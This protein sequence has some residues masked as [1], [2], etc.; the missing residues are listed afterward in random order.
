MIMGI[1][2]RLGCDSENQNVFVLKLNSS[3]GLLQ[4]PYFISVNMKIVEKLFA[5]SIST[6]EGIGVAV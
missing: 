3:E 6:R 4:E 1:I 2:L 5:Y